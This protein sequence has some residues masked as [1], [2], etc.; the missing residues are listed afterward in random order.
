MDIITQHDGYEYLSLSLVTLF[1]VPQIY[2]G[3]K[4]GSLKD[5]SAASLW[6]VFF[7]SALWG[8]Y[9][10]EHNLIYFSIPTFFVTLCSSITLL[11]KLKFYYKRVDEHF[12]SF[13]QPSAPPTFRI[14]K[15]QV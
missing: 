15:D 2:S 7:G 8:N 14:E 3:Y 12:V 6:F 13:D 10:I 9:M 5:V 1:L 11:M 4:S